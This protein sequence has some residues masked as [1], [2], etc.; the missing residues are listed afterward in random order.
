[1]TEKMMVGWR[2]TL[3]LP[4]L[5]IEKINAKIDTGAKT[6]CLHAFKVE[7]F[8]RD[9]QPW[10]RFS[11][12]PIQRD[13]SLVVECEAP[14]VDERV[15]RDSGG[16]EEKRY[17]IVATIELGQQRWEA[18]ITLTNRENMAFRMLL[19]RTSMH[20]RITVDPVASFLIPFKETK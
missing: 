3:S 5:G 9:E 7:P 10:V 1:M 17:V 16:H 15:V 8:T 2:E 14:V 12:H 13:D 20:H 4:S 11:M 19:G 18:E 6:S